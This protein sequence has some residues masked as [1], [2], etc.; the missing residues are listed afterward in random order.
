MD[1]I[2]DFKD[3]GREYSVLAFWFLNGELE[4]ERLARQIGQMVEKGVYGGFLHPRAYLKTPYLEDRWWDA[5]GACVEESRKQGFAPWLYDE[6][7]WP[8]GTAGSTFEYGFQKPSR[9][10]SRGRDN[11]AKGLRVVKREA[12]EMGCGNKDVGK[13]GAIK[14]GAINPESMPY[15]VAERDGF[16]YEF[17]E[18]VFEKAVDYLNPDTIASFIKLTH[19][20][21]RKRWGADFGKLIPGI[22]FDEIY[23]MG[24]PLP[25]TDRLPG[26]FRETY[27]YDILDELPSLVDGASDRDRQVRKDYFS[28][29][30]SMYE[31][32]FFRQIS[33]WC[34]KY[35]LKLTGHTEEF[36]W[37]HPRRQ[38]DYFKTMR[39][40]MV[41]GSDCHDYRYRYPRRITYC[42]PKYS[43]SVARIYGKER[44]MSEA[45][46]GAGWNCTMEEFKK[47]INTLAAMGTGMF[48]LHGFYYECE[49][50]GS[51]SDWPTSFFYQNPYWDYF[52]IFADYI[53][54]LS[55]MNSQ[56]NP[57]VDYAILYPIGDMDENMENGEENPAG[58][59]INSGFHQA[60]NI[61][62]EHQLDTDMVD[63]ES[64]LNA[65]ICGGKLY[66]GQQRFKVLLLPEGGSLMD[67]TV[68]KLEA[69]T[70]DG[71]SVL[72]YR[73]GLA[74]GNLADKGG[75]TA[76]K[77]NVHSISGIAE[78]AASLA[79][80]SASVIYG[81]PGGIFLNH[82]TAGEFDYYLVANSSDERRNLVLSFCH[83]STPALLDI[84]KGE[85]VQASYR[86][87]KG[88]QMP[89][90]RQDDGVYLY[91]DLE[92][93]EAVYALFGL[94]EDTVSRA[95]PALTGDI[96]WEEE[97][98]TGKW[99]F[100]PLSPSCR[101]HGDGIY[102]GESTELEIPV[103]EFTSDVS[104]GT[105]TIRICNQ[106]GEEGE[107]GR[108]LSLWSGQWITRR[109]SWN[110]Q[111]DAS[112]LYFR[113]TVLLEDTPERAEFCVAAVDSFECF[114]NG[115]MVYRGISNGEPVVFED[116]GLLVQGENT[117]AIHVTNR[118]PLM[119]V[120]VCSAE[121]L[122]PD[123]FISLL[124]E[125]TIVCKTS[126]EA[127]KSDSTWIV[128]DSL[129]DGWEQPDSDGRFT[130]A[131][132]DVQKVKNFNNP[133]L[134][135]VWLHAWE[136]GK[137]PLK[138]W[139]D[140]P[141]FG[142]TLAYPRKLWYTV[143]IPAGAS[144]IHEP[145]TAGAVTCMLDGKEVRWENG[146]CI[147]PDN[148]RIH[149]LTIQVTAYGSG[150]GLKQPVRVSMEEVST[151]LQ[152]WRM[153]GLPWFSGKCRYTNTWSVKQP[154]GTYMLELGGVNHCAQ[155]WVN[156][157]LADTRLWRPYRADITSLLRPGENEITIVVSNLASNERRH[158]LVDEGMA[159][160]WN[161]YWNEDNMDRDS[162][163][164]VSGLLGPVRLLH[165]AS[166]ENK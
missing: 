99:K 139:G 39:H 37:E 53:R 130:A 59:A 106:S 55:F 146:R 166:P 33:D 78:A 44:A 77:G 140:L 18:N 10:L 147:L 85:M 164:Y 63:E 144:V 155:I 54:R 131:G 19:E 125:G 62:I 103:A 115:T 108:H 97:W 90:G 47:G 40:L 116:K 32:A 68:E 81:N 110:D 75:R 128:N 41:P 122:P 152:D 104:S 113:K 36:L 88:M 25:W 57:V 124:M 21:Y 2:H 9:I 114:I 151:N 16:V 6:Y 127:V 163:N 153:L 126:V 66:V 28:L 73:T 112:D 52:K 93:G 92:P 24:N 100:L 4:K 67:E 102:D 159:L 123:R 107:C 148:E 8:S 30:T 26:R 141:L 27:G 121:E 119:D 70:K 94:G 84:E 142:Q 149:I 161:R 72:F 138:P 98:I 133:G 69:W 17:Y 14:P 1:L 145:V 71:G 109:R 64:I 29:V 61:M 46:G 45:L 154:E 49:H 150:D 42:E 86:R 101:N 51:Q 20:E 156:G 134:E 7:A 58:Q 13:P 158:M 38:G 132:F 48:I 160:G 3:P 5:V 74:G 22:F 117:L 162:R 120:Y 135:H 89:G 137:P 31:E 50:Q 79:P 15:H 65:R 60:L 11:M 118:K 165:L 96:R 43:V 143:T 111:L 105:E 76:L 82:R 95:K 23:M 129:R 83:N 91:L 87:V 136:R 12:G 157:R 34:G 35:G 56:G 80:P